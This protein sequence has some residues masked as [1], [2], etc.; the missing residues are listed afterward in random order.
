MKNVI[1]FQQAADRG[2]AVSET[3]ENQRPVG[4]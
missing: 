1:A 2:F 3:A 4:D